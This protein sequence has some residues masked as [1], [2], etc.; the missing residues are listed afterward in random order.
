MKTPVTP[1]LTSTSTSGRIQ[2]E[3]I[4]S[5]PRTPAPVAAHAV[6]SVRSLASRS[7]S[8]VSVAMT[9]LLLQRDDPQGSVCSN[10]RIK[11]K[12]DGR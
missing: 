7:V 10:Y 3:V 1:R 4:D 6:V 12:F 2:Q 9:P 5:A 11:A 8:I